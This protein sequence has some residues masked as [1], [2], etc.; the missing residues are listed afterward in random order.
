M[1]LLFYF[2]FFNLATLVVAC[3]TAD[4]ISNSNKAGQQPTVKDTVYRDLKYID[5]GV[6]YETN[7]R[8]YSAKGDFNSFTWWHQIAFAH[9]AYTVQGIFV[10]YCCSSH[11][12][13]KP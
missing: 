9:R 8:Q 6:I 7:I 5:Q 13:T 10:W 2:I 3:S 12:A 4:K 1:R 11:L